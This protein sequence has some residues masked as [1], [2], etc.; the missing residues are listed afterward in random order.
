MFRDVNYIGFEKSP[1]LLVKCER[2]QAAIERMMERS[3]ERLA[4]TWQL[5]ESSRATSG[6][7]IDRHQRENDDPKIDF[8]LDD[9]WSGVQ[10]LTIRAS[11]LD[12]LE[13]LLSRV[14]WLHIELLDRFLDEQSRLRKQ[15]RTLEVAL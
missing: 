6:E 14:R 11:Q 10:G 13:P 8:R 7:S 4:A 1:N 2:A 12:D 9:H 5:Q 15:E 3:A